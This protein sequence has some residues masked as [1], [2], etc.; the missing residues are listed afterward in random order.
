MGP[1]GLGPWAVAK[2][3]DGLLAYLDQFM[4]KVRASGELYALQEKW[5]G[6][7]FKDMPSAPTK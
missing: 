1:T 4:A 3:N 7:A 5:L 6:R 2:G